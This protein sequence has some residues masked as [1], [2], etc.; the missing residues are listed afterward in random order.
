MS[1]NNDFWKALHVKRS[2]PSATTKIKKTPSDLALPKRASTP[3][4]PVFRS[5]PRVR[6]QKPL[7]E[8]GSRKGSPPKEPVFGGPKPMPEPKPNRSRERKTRFTVTVD[9]TS[10]ENRDSV[11]T[12]AASEGRT[13]SQWARRV[14]LA[15]AD[16]KSQ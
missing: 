2:K 1:D 11:R 3:S 6:A 14:L 12:A 5:A 7:W 8:T 9:M 16:P 13:F 15:A 4:E 10:A